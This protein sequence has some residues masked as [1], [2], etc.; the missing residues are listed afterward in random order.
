MKI[1]IFPFWFLLIFSLYPLCNHANAAYREIRTSQGKVIV[2]MDKQE[3]LERFGYPAS[4]TEDLWYYSLPE[5]FFVYLSPSLFISLYPQFCE[6]HM[7]IPLEFKVYDYLSDFKIR[8]VTSEVEWLIDEP[9]NF[10]LKRAGVIIPKRSG[11]YQILAKYKGVFSNS[12]YINVKEAKEKKIE[13]EKLLSIDVLP[14]RPHIPYRGKLNFAA[15][16]TFFY[17]SKNEYL[18][19][20]MGQ[21]VKWF[22]QQAEKV[23]GVKGKEI[24]FPSLGKFRVF[25]KYKDLESFP[26]ET[27]VSELTFPLKQTL[28]HIRLLPEFILMPRGNTVSLKVY[29]TYH[30]NRIEEITSRVNWKIKD[31]EI[32]KFDKNGVFLTKSEGITEVI[33]ELDNLE[34]LPT[35]IIVFGRKIPLLDMSSLY[36]TKKEEIYSKDLLKDIKDDVEKLSK[37]FFGEEK[38]LSLIKIIPDYARIAVGENKQLGAQGTYG[39]GSQEDLTLLGKWSSS[40]DKIVGV[41]KGKISGISRGE[42]KIHI[43]Y[44]GVKSLPASIEIEGPKLVSIILSPDNSQISMRDTLNLK[45]E[46][47]FTDSSRNDITSLV[48]W[49]VTRPRIIKIEKGRVRPL[50]IGQTQVYAEYLGI[51]SLPANIKIIVTLGWIMWVVFKVISLLVLI[52]IMAFLVLYFLTEKEKNKLISIYRN[53]REFIISL[54]ENL[55]NILII[56]GLRYEGFLPP[57]SYAQLVEKRYSIRDNIFLRFTSRFE[58]AKYSQHILQSNDAHLAL[59]EYNNFLKILFSRQHRSSLL[60]RHCLALLHRRPLFIGKISY[61]TNLYGNDIIT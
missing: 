19:K 8:D 26:Q 57:L 55:N 38:K 11:N 42:S 44:Q 16:G 46:G 43:E 30:N 18:V 37:G 25:C 39:D 58:E 61:F 6:G 51:K 40:D 48:N 32:L 41:S 5:K 53:P 3:A 45:A 12:G 1:K 47:Y 50:R 9:E 27:Q 24:Y 17:P 7:D 22:V 60:L 56:F 54:Y 14:Y 35:K 10:V 29:G 34:S 13:E 31:K 59:D 23:I 28:K 20:D 4:V 33:A 52:I 15:L 2:G 36:K 49:E 21:E